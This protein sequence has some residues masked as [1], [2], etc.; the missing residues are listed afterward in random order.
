MIAAVIV[1][2]VSASATAPRSALAD[3]GVNRLP[4]SWRVEITTKAQGSFPGL[5]TFTSDGAVIATESPGPFES[6]G[7]G[8]WVR[9]GRDVDLTFLVLFGSAAGGGRNTGS[10]KIVSTLHFDAH[11]G[12]WTGLFKIQ[13]FNAAG[14][15]VFD[16]CGE[17]R[18][19]RIEVETFDCDECRDRSVC[20]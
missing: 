5:L 15:L 12:G 3:Q 16:D 20:S 11:A 8:N 7:H 18:L 6:P 1:M 9:R 2:L 19:T 4:G 13:V 10:A 17:F 14:G